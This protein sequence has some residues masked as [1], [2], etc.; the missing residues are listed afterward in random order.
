MTYEKV[1]RLRKG[2]LSTTTCRNKQDGQN[3]WHYIVSAAKLNFRMVK[4]KSKYTNRKYT[5]D[6]IFNGNSNVCHICHH[7]R[8]NHS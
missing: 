7:S 2:V 1:S 3:K 4:I 5:F 6:F 8:D